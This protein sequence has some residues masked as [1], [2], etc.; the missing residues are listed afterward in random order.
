MR[1]LVP[2]L[3][4][5]LTVLFTAQSAW[6]VYTLSDNLYLSI[7]NGT[8][9]CIKI[10]LPDDLGVSP[11]EKI[12]Y[13]V[14]MEPSPLYTWG[15]VSEEI[16]AADANNTVK[17]RVCFTSA[18]NKEVG[19]CGSP[20]TLKISAPDRPDLPNRTVKG[21]VCISEYRDIET[22]SV[23][24]GQNT[25]DVINTGKDVFDMALDK[26]V[27]YAEPGNTTVFKLKAQSYA[28]L[29]LQV[30]VDGVTASPD[31]FTL[32]TTESGTVQEQDITITAPQ[33]KGEHA[34][35][36]NARMQGCTGQY[37]E[38]EVTG[39]LMVSD[40]A[41]EE[42]GWTVS[43]F[44]N[45]IN[46]KNLEPVEFEATVENKGQRATFYAEV[47]SAAGTD[48]TPANLDIPQ[49]GTRSV[50]FK[51]TPKE[52]STTYEVAVKVTAGGLTKTKSSFLSVNEILT[53]SIRESEEV[54]SQNPGEAENVDDSLDS[55]ID[56]YRTSDYGEEMGE[57]GSLK[58]TL[59]SARQKTRTGGQVN[60]TQPTLPPATIGGPEEPAGFD[61]TIVIIGIAAAAVIGV[62]LFLYRKKQQG[63]GE[64]QAEFEPVRQD[65]L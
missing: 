13:M 32:T 6:A 65:C 5:A 12:D 54:K 55:F 62:A 4:L 14:T 15:D 35:T 10:Y 50:K 3:A 43:L 63:G 16:H 27:R 33:E 51:V 52:V 23:A 19:E 21:G 25:S 39:K 38:K 22:T 9:E 26:R 2:A 29:V 31:T 64:V 53:D 1:K 49:E 56:S 37:C 17:T 61:W 48:F 57:Y 8:V 34:F 46:V 58:D 20:F 45:N 36:V 11:P 18:I 30:S 60:Q 28:D 7:P 42:T 44:P 59:N 24:P 40:E 41:P 47:L